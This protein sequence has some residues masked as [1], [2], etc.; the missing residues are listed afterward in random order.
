MIVQL[1]C[2]IFKVLNNQQNSYTPHELVPPTGACF[3]CSIVIIT[4]RHLPAR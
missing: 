2:T 4:A 1:S 3:R